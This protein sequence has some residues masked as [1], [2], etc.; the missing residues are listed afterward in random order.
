MA[1]Q[2]EEAQTIEQLEQLEQKW[3][4]FSS[5]TVLRSTGRTMGEADVMQFAGVSGDFERLHT[6]AEFAGGTMYGQRIA[7]GLLTLSVTSTLAIPVRPFAALA[8]YGYESIRFV[9][10]V[11]FG[12]TVTVELSFGSLRPRNDGTAVVECRY[13][14]FNQRGE[15]VMTAVH[16]MLVDRGQLMRDLDALMMRAEQRPISA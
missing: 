13:H 10:A 15:I 6:D 4:A 5:F 2:S 3:E 14:T 1:E 11:P 16:L 12:D 7:H 8:S 9:R